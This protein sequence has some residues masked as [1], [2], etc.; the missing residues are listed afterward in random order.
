MARLAARKYARIIQKLGFPAQFKARAPR[1]PHAA[2]RARALTRRVSW[3]SLS[4]SLCRVSRHQDFTIQNIVASCDVKFPIRLE[5]L[6]YAHASFA[7]VRARR[8][9]RVWRVCCPPC[10]FF[11]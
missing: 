4:L 2:Q 10:A 11:V 8:V 3:L 1:P 9:A 5:G 6:A 7:N